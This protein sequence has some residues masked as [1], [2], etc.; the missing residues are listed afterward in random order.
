[1]HYQCIQKNAGRLHSKNNG[2]RLSQ[3]SYYSHQYH[4]CFKFQQ[5]IIYTILQCIHCCRAADT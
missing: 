2:L 5:L 4:N 3:F 1:M